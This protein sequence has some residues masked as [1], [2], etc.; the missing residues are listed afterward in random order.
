M[1]QSLRGRRAH[2]HPVDHDGDL[3]FEVDAIGLSGKRHVLPGADEI[4]GP[5][6]VHERP[7]QLAFE[8]SVFEGALHEIAVTVKGRGVEP[9]P[10][11]G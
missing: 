7:S 6:L 8:G 10:R 3:A 11:T 1:R 4:V 2:R 5:A 9:L